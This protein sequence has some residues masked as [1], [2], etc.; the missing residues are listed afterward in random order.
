MDMVLHVE[1]KQYLIFYNK[2]TLTFLQ[3]AFSLITGHGLQIREI[4][5]TKFETLIKLVLNKGFPK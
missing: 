1:L 5:C 4:G 3:L 2:K